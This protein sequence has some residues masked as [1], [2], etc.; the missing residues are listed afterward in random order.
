MIVVRLSDK[1]NY[2]VQRTIEEINSFQQK[3]GK[4]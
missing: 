1:T 3:E 2:N 4:R